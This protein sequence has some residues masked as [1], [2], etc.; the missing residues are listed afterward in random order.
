MIWEILVSADLEGMTD[1]GFGESGGSA[2]FGEGLLSGI[3]P[4]GEIGELRF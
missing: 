1:I 3:N 2:N 4:D